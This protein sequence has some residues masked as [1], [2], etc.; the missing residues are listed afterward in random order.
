M[1]VL[2]LFI[3]SINNLQCRLCIGGSL[4]LNNNGA[5]LCM[6]TDI[7]VTSYILTGMHTKDFRFKKCTRA[8]V[9][10]NIRDK[11]CKFTILLQIIWA[12]RGHSI[13]L[14]FQSQWSFSVGHGPRMN[15]RTDDFFFFTA[16]GATPR[17]FTDLGRMAN[18]KE[19]YKG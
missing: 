7:F 14:L 5:K 18:L 15:G 10:T 13:F 2:K 1:A 17:L 11:T 19:T 12:L 8:T 16:T 4:H 3:V 9:V 6:L